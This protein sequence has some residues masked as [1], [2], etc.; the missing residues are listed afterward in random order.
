MQALIE[1]FG[2]PNKYDQAAYGTLC[3]VRSGERFEFYRQISRN[4]QEPVW[5]LLEFPDSAMV[6]EEI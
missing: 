2:P 6:F 5:S 4:S 3:R 1:R